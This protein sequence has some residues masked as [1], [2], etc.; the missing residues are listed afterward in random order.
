MSQLQGLVMKRLLVSVTLL[1]C[2]LFA[3][4]QQPLN[5]WIK[6]PAVISS[7]GIVSGTTNLPDGTILSIG[8]MGPP[9][10]EFNR[11]EG[12][13]LNATNVAVSHGAFGPVGITGMLCLSPGRYAY[14]VIMIAPF[15]QPPD[16]IAIIGKDG[17]NLT[18]PLVSGTGIGRGV[19][20]KIPVE[21]R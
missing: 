7:N 20:A 12:C 8:L 9:G 4:A 18:G 16:V 10:S 21:V 5:V 1:F 2:S 17:S 14:N 11:Q 19:Q 3:Y 6:L 15:M 13:A